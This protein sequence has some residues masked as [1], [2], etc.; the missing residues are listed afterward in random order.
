MKRNS[1]VVVISLALCLMASAATFTVTNIL[2]SGVG[3]LRAAITAANTT[4]GANRIEFAITPFDGTVK[5]IAPSNALP[6][7]TNSVVI[8]GYTQMGSS[9][10][11]LAI[12]D[13]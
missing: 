3:S 13:N 2:D 1:L 4:P 9:S 10:N 5:T 12:G 8:D 11:T 6:V 7:I